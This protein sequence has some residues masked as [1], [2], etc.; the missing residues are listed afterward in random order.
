M[1]NTRPLEKVA[2]MP[3]K[4]IAFTAASHL[5]SMA[6]VLVLLTVSTASWA[7]KRTFEMT[8]EDTKIM[9]VDKQAFHT[10]A[11]NGQVPRR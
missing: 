11:F 9:L 4:T 2:H 3:Q 10:F 5:K 1:K 7:E 8:I 6:F